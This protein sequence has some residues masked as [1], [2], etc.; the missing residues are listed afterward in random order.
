LHPKHNGP[1]ANIDSGASRASGTGATQQVDNQKVHNGFVD[2]RN[3]AL[4]PQKEQIQASATGLTSL[5]VKVKAK[6]P[7]E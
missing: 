2:R 5:P 6:A 4:D 3:E 1:T 7:T